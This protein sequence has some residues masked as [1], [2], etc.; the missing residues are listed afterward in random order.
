M[1]LEV[2]IITAIV[3]FIAAFLSGS[4]AVGGAALMTAV[5]TICLGGEYADRK[6]VV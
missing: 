4:T 6:S 2:Y 1:G 3:G 5:L